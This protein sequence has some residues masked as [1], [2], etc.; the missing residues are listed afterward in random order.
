MVPPIDVLAGVEY[1]TNREATTL[2]EVP[3]SVVV[4]GG[5]PV[6]IELAQFL[7]RFDAEVLVESAER[8]LARKDPAVSELLVETLRAE[9]IERLGVQA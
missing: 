2:N 7:R 6:G 9:G 1:W 8:L 4:L 5:R 3:S